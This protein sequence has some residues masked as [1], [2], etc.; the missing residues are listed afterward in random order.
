MSAMKEV[1]DE[2]ENS[3]MAN[4]NP[5]VQVSPATWHLNGDKVRLILVRN[6]EPCD[7]LHSAWR[8]KAFP[9]DGRYHT[10]DLNQ[11]TKVISRPNAADSFKNDSPLTAVGSVC[12]QFVGRAIGMRGIRLHAVYSSPSLRCIQSC[13]S[14]L[15]VSMQKHHP[16]I[17][18]EPGL[19]EP[20]SFYWQD[21][22]P[23]FLSA[24]EMAE[25]GYPMDRDYQPVMSVDQLNDE[26]YK[27]KSVGDLYKRLKKVAE[28][29]MDA[30][31]R[32]SDGA[33]LVVCHATTID[34]IVRHFQDRRDLPH[35][36]HDLIRC[37]LA[38][39]FGSTVV[40]ERDVRTAIRATKVKWELNTDTIPPTSFL[41]MSSQI[42]VPRY[43]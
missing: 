27:E 40:L 33:I 2:K 41:H 21:G 7:R 16:R 1:D 26:L 24:E 14:L 8:F 13:N 9:A 23:K 32:I 11:P 12:S 19:F 10:M 30:C 43:E 29:L 5:F 20:L 28:M 31:N 6:G 36:S 35:G 37:G 15:S 38:Y 25:H 22:V 34:A 4:E 3:Q 39:P 18:I 17:C 42:Q